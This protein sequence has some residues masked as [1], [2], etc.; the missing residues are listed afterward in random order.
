MK[1]RTL[2]CFLIFTLCV[3]YTS[4]PTTVFGQE[5]SLAEQVFDRHSETLQREDIQAVLPQ[6]LNALKDPAF[7]QNP[8]DCS[9]G[10][11]GWCLGFGSSES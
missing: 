7:Q 4:I 9:T 5:V 11:V 1:K 8:P 3:L 2:V 6:V 10:R